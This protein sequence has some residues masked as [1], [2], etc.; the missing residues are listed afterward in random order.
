MADPGH[1]Q[2]TV[3]ILRADGEIEEVTRIDEHYFVDGNENIAPSRTPA[4]GQR[5]VIVLRLV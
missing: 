5:C 3:A 4:E 1:A 2:A